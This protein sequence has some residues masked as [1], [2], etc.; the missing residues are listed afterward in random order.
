MAI[1][2]GGAAY[3]ASNGVTYI[4]DRYFTG[5][6]VT[7]WSWV[8]D[9]VSTKDDPIYLSERWGD[10]QYNIPMSN[11]SYDV[12]LQFSELHW[13]APGDRKISAVLENIT[14]LYDFD[15]F[16]SAGYGSALDLNFGNIQV[17]D[18]NLTIK[19]S[20]T[21][22]A[23]TL[24]GIVVKRA[25]VTSSSGVAGTGSAT[26]ATAPTTPANLQAASIRDKQITLSWGQSSDNVA[27]VGYKIYRNGTYVGTATGLSYIDSGLTAD[28]TY[29]YTVKA[30]DAAGNESFPIALIAK[31]YLIAGNVTLTWAQPSQRAD[32][33]PLPP[34]E[35]GGYQVRYKLSSA[36]SY[37]LIK[38][39]AGTYSYSISNLVGDYVFEI[40]TYD[41]AGVYSEF[42]RFS[43]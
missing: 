33:S 24:A 12:I 4:A 41:T 17:N 23:G 30:V 13:S 22:D 19:L 8:E 16:K 43:L 38:V 29:Q 3:S 11:G 39:P 26:D 14:M 20:A 7:D 31:T 42:I 6:E 21:A 28:T 37:T 1:N 10:F 5:G 15:I 35:I 40:A 34:S 25:A 36:T 18:G 2:V 27:V 9:V 32:L